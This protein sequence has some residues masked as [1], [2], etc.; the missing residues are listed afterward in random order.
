MISTTLKFFL[1]IF[2]YLNGLLFSLILMYASP[3][4]M[5]HTFEASLFFL[6]SSVVLFF[7]LYNLS[8]VNETGNLMK[9]LYIL[10]LVHIILNTIVLALIPKYAHPMEGVVDMPAVYIF[11]FS[12]LLLLLGL[13]R[14]LFKNKERDN[15]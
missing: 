12:G 4:N 5:G 15:A 13:I 8:F 6:S 11:S 9:Y 1:V 14:M 2:I 3:D 10:L 7:I